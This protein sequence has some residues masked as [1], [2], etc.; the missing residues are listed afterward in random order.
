V[1]L[2]ELARRLARWVDVAFEQALNR[3]RY[4]VDNP[5]GRG[6]QQFSLTHPLFPKDK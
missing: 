2:E 6:R 4:G 5:G 3:F 1:N